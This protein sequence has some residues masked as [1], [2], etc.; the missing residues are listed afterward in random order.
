M[1]SAAECAPLSAAVTKAAHTRVF[2]LTCQK[3]LVL[4]AKRQSDIAAAVGAKVDR[5][6]AE[7][8]EKG[9]S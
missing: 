8:S 4:P 3:P 1:L 5:A 6:A 7:R 9:L 2:R